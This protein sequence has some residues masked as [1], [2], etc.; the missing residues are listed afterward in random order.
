MYKIH[1]KYTINIYFC[2]LNKHFSSFI[3]CVRKTLAF[4]VE[5]CYYIEKHGQ[6][7]E[8]HH[9]R[10]RSQNQRHCSDTLRNRQLINLQQKKMF[11]HLFE[12]WGQINR[13]KLWP[14]R[15]LSIVVELTNDFNRGIKIKQTSPQKKSWK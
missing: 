2:I 10:S 6:S 5:T 11:V 15:I 7:I 12:M 9:T 3:S 14:A 4:T 1:P 8:W 13:I